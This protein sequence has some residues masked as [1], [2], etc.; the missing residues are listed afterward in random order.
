VTGRTAA[1]DGFTHERLGRTGIRVH[2]LGLAATYRP[3]TATIRHAFERGVNLVFFFGFDAQMTRVLR[4]IVRA[5]R[6]SVVI[7][8]G[9]YNYVWWR[10]NLRRALERRLRTLGT[11]H[12]DLFLFLGI[13]NEREF[14]DSARDELLRFRDEGRVR[15][16]G[17]STHNRAFAGRLAAAGDLDVLMI[18]YNA[19]HRRAERDI[20][21]HLQP[22]DPGVVCYTATRW[23]ALLRRP[24]GWPKSEPMPPAGDLYRFTLSNPH[25]HACLTAPR[26]MQEL[27]EN[28]DAVER[29]PL[30]DDELAF[31]CRFGDAV[32]ARRKW[33]MGG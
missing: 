17:L 25:V 32:Y 10:Q 9:A 22:H 31:V 27:D 13:L 33:F 23:T 1:A 5:D 21:P 4:D 12:L 30:G 29:G 3:G 7:A 19:A 2:R 11:D 15:A 26:S 8:T 20:F 24:R 28:L 6:A 18:R 14:P 16:V